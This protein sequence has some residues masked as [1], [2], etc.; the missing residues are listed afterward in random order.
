MSALS[1]RVSLQAAER[2]IAAKR[3]QLVLSRIALEQ[4]PMTANDRHRGLREALANVQQRLIELEARR[5]TVVRAPV[6]GRIAAIPAL[7]GAGVDSG[8]LI[9]TIVPEGAELRARLFVPTRAIGKVH[10][11]QDVAIRYDAF[12]YQKYGTFKGRVEEVA[13]S[14]LLPQEIEKISPVRTSEPAYVLDVAIERQQVAVGGDRQV[15]LR[16]DMLF[17]AT[18]QVDRRPILAWVGESVFGVAQR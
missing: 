2:E 12:P 1:Q 9:A 18:I 3:A 5:A 15:H 17:S 10:P 11:G 7:A 4:L 13:N 8:V 6:G 16:P 14:V